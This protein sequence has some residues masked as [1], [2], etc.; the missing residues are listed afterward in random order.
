MLPVVPDPN[1]PLSRRN[2]FTGVSSQQH[3]QCMHSKIGSAGGQNWRLGRPSVAHAY[4]VPAPPQAGGRGAGKGCWQRQAQRP[5]PQPVQW[6]EAA[7]EAAAGGKKQGGGLC[8][9]GFTAAVGQ[10]KT[11]RQTLSRV[12]SRV[13]AGFGASDWFHLQEGRA[14]RQPG[15]PSIL[16]LGHGRRCSGGQ[17]HARPPPQPPQPASPTQAECLASFFTPSSSF[18]MEPSFSTSTRSGSRPAHSQA[19]RCGGRGGGESGAGRKWRP[20]EPPLGAG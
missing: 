13:G 19:G 3:R 15:G 20:L 10:R 11:W 16:L 1:C 14:G 6:V 2:L 12:W 5:L 7:D 8:V 9:L 18:H 4:E 17:Q